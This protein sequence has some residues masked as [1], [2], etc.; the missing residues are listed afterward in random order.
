MSLPIQNIRLAVRN[1][2]LLWPRCY[3]R[4]VIQGQLYA[5]VILSFLP[6]RNMTVEYSCE[7]AFSFSHTIALIRLTGHGGDNHK[8]CLKVLG[9]KVRCIEEALNLS[10]L[11]W[12][13]HDLHMPT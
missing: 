1:L 3:V 4:L 6:I 7:R 9:P 5:A 12:L 11:R 8:V 13:G 10:R 2:R